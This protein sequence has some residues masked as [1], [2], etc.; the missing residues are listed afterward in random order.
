MTARHAAARTCVPYE[1][2][3]EPKGGVATSTA[4]CSQHNDA[5]RWRRHS[6]THGERNTYP[7]LQQTSWMSSRNRRSTTATPACRGLL[8]TNAHDTRGH[9]R[10]HAAAAARRAPPPDMT[11]KHVLA[12]DSANGASSVWPTRLRHAH[13]CA[14]ETTQ[15]ARRD[16]DHHASARTSCPE[17][18]QP[19]ALIRCC[20]LGACRL[21]ACSCSTQT[22]TASRCASTQ[23]AAPSGSCA[24]G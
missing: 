8:H 24:A 15:R 16:T 10:H 22:R 21:A 14:R 4:L 11:L 2:L 1:L 18:A 20:L 17:R 19:L 6:C 13:N 12:M 5:S 7:A 3:P 23:D 9:A